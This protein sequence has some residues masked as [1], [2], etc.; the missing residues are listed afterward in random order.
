MSRHDKRIL[1]TSHAAMTT[2]PATW[3]AFVLNP[4][5]DTWQEGVPPDSSGHVPAQQGGLSPRLPPWSADSGHLTKCRL[6][7]PPAGFLLPADH[8]PPAAAAAAA[9]APAA[10][11]SG[12]ETPGWRVPAGQSM[13]ASQLGEEVSC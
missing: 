2:K 8:C 6:A 3:P 12:K 1:G 5:R 10:A 7:Q 11:D 13:K 9:P 4:R